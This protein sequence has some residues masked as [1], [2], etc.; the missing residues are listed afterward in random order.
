MAP[1]S[2]NYSNKVR[3]WLLTHYP[4]VVTEYQIPELFRIAYMKSA[5]MLTAV[6]CFRKTGISPLNT[7]VFGDWMFESSETTNRSFPEMDSAIPNLTTKSQTQTISLQELS[8][9]SCSESETSSSTTM[10]SFTIASPAEIVSISN[11]KTQ[12]TRKRCQKSK[13]AILT[14]SPYKAELAKKMVI[15][16]KKRKNAQTV[17]KT[18]E[19]KNDTPAEI[20]SRKVYPQQFL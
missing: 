19:T 14:S 1:F 15:K 3:I 6:N 10:A 13:T 18:V 17:D 8:L 7:E 16:T 5:N 11:E 20:V 4:R 9:T 12:Q 2:S